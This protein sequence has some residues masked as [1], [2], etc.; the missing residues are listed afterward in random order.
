MRL[1]PKMVSLKVAVGASFVQFNLAIERYHLA[2]LRHDVYRRTAVVKNINVE[3][4]CILIVLHAE[5]HVLSVAFRLRY[6]EVLCHAAEVEPLSASVRYVI[7]PAEVG[8]IRHHAVAFNP[9]V[10]VC[11]QLHRHA[12]RW[13]SRLHV[14]LE[15]AVAHR[16]AYH[17]GLLLFLSVILLPVRRGACHK[18][19]CRGY[20]K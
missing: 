8:Q 10:E 6:L 11:R 20:Y 1:S 14:Y 7:S 5:L 9:Q 2:L 12:S 3:F 13:V 15:V 16:P 17:L 18:N 19:Y 4:I